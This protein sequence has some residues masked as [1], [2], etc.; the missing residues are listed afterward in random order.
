MHEKASSVT[1]RHSAQRSSTKPRRNCPHQRKRCTSGASWRGRWTSPDARP[2]RTAR[3]STVSSGRR[4]RYPRPSPST[5]PVYRAGLT[6]PGFALRAELPPW[7]EA[8][9]SKGRAPLKDIPV[10]R[11]AAVFGAAADASTG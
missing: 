1:S 3:Y 7:P 2:S 6:R 10:E 8:L 11:A 9:G 4:R 5:S